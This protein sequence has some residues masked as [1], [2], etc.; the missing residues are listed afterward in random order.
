MAIRTFYWAH[1]GTR[2]AGWW[3]TAPPKIMEFGGLRKCPRFRAPDVYHD[4]TV[5]SP[6]EVVAM[7]VR[8]GVLPARRSFKIV[9][10]PSEWA[11]AGLRRITEARVRP[12]RALK[13]PEKDGLF[14]PELVSPVTRDGAPQ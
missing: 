12:R 11:A 2:C 10:L 9:Q 14:R 1:S 3:D 8:H 6:D 13:N 4:R 5:G 7:L